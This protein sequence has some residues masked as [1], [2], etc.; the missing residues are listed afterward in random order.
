MKKISR[1]LLLCV[2]GLAA[3]CNKEMATPESVDS[4]LTDELSSK[5]IRPLAAGMEPYD[6]LGYGYD[7]TGLY[8][9]A[10]SAGFPVVDINRFK[11]DHPARVIEERP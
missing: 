6:V 1:L 10:A 2:V 5:T 9:N 4:A 7:V 11:E 3:S 8:A